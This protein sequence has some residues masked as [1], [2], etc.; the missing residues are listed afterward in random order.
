[1]KAVRYKIAL[2]SLLTLPAMLLVAVGAPATAAPHLSA[3]GA[4]T[5]SNL[6]SFKPTFT[7]PAAT[8]CASPGCHLLTGPF[9]TP[10]TAH[11][12]AG[13]T[14]A[15]AAKSQD[16][17]GALP[18]IRPRVPHVNGPTVTIPTV[19]CQP[20]RPGCDT[21]SSFAGGAASVKGINAV[22]SATHTANIFKDV[23]PPDQGL[24]AGNGSVVEANNIGEILIFNQ[25]L[26][27]ASPVISLD[28]VMGLTKLHW[29][30]GGDPS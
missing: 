8:G 17:A 7:G 2:L 28:R 13:Q 6:G 3:A 9:R 1:M 4:V 12:S 22:D 30:S 29:S 18:L 11:L 5:S 14:R 26:K 27:R 10:S 25:A 20:L 19:S 23:E 16:R 21:I 24:C 15:G